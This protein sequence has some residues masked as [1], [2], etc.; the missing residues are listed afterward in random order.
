MQRR[1]GARTM[2]QIW[3]SKACLFQGLELRG[4]REA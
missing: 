4:M 3:V 1:V 2:A